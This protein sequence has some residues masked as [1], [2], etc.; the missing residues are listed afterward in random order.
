[1]TP[2]AQIGQIAIG[3]FIESVVYCLQHLHC[4]VLQSIIFLWRNPLWETRFLFLTMGLKLYLRQCSKFK[5][6]P[7]VKPADPHLRGGKGG[8]RKWGDGVDRGR[9]TG[10]GKRRGRGGG[11]RSWDLGS[12]NKESRVGRGRE[13]EWAPNVQGKFFTPMQ[14]SEFYILWAITR[15][16]PIDSQELQRM[17]I[18][19]VF[20]DLLL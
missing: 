13:R 9:G 5:H 16:L 15:W 6:F 3:Q 7:G 1:M 14:T 10:K 4:F 19:H 20:Y 11:G 18:M 17:P 8:K 2:A 12:V